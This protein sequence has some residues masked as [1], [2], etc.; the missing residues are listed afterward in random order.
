MLAMV[1]AGDADCSFVT[2]FVVG[3]VGSS[4]DGDAECSFVGWLGCLGL[5][6][7]D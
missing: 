3:Y 4:G 6:V 5:V 2:A 7:L 1:E